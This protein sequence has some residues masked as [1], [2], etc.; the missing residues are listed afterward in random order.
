MFETEA[1]RAVEHPVF[2]LL[3]AIFRECV[4]DGV[5]RTRLILERPFVIGGMVYATDRVVCVRTA[6][7]PELEAMLAV[8]GRRKAPRADAVFEVPG[9]FLAEPVELP[10]MSDAPRCDLCLGVGSFGR[11]FCEHCC[12]PS[13]AAPCHVCLGSGVVDGGNIGPD[14]GRGIRVSYRYV[15]LLKRH[16]CSSVYPPNITHQGERCFPVRFQVGD[17]EGVVMPLKYDL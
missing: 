9:G 11:G 2:V 5:M 6:A 3:P 14:L 7:T 10:D 8:E 16:G 12:I 4:D 1:D 13:P 17:V 15:A